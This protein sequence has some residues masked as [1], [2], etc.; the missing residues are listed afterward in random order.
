MVIFQKMCLFKISVQPPILR[1]SKGLL[2]SL[3]ARSGTPHSNW[4]LVK[5]TLGLKVRISDFHPKI[6]ALS[7]FYD[8]TLLKGS[9]LN[10]K[11][12]EIESFLHSKIITPQKSLRFFL[13][14]LKHILYRLRPLAYSWIREEGIKSQSL[15]CMYC[16][17]N[18]IFWRKTN[19]NLTTKTNRSQKWY[20]RTAKSRNQ[21]CS[22]TQSI[23]GGGASSSKF[24]LQSL[25]LR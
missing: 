5:E 13:Y 7:P 18:P 2:F 15:H 1:N 17:P 10:G 11:A 23:W 12:T 9:L 22:K 4:N 25:N 16:W 14:W 8:K 19:I 20:W 21:W 3:I 6:R 24:H